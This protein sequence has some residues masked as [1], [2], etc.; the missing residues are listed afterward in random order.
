M[1]FRGLFVLAPHAAA[2][3]VGADE[4]PV[5]PGQVRQGFIQIEPGT[6]RDQR[7]QIVDVERRLVREGR[8][9]GAHPVAVV[10]VVHLLLPVHDLA[11]R[12]G[13]G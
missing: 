13:G 7:G 9:S 8:Q 5:P 11:A 10:D 4:V 3:V 6:R 12:L 1:I 2:D